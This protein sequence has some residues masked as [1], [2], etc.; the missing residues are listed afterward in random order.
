MEPG[1]PIWGTGSVTDTG[2]MQP[3]PEA[4][5]WSLRAEAWAN[6]DKSGGGSQSGT[7]SRWSDVAA[8]GRPAIPADGVGWRTS[9][10]EWRATTDTGRWRQ[11]TEWR[12]ASGTHGWRQTTEAWQSGDN[13]DFRPPIDPPATQLPAI[14]GTAWPTPD[15]TDQPDSSSSSSRQSF[16]GQS[17]QS[18]D[19]PRWQQRPA[20]A[21]PSWQQSQDPPWQQRPADAPPTWSRG[22][23]APPWQQR[24]ADAPAARPS[25]QQFTTPAGPT[26]GPSAQPADAP[27]RGE[28]PSWDSRPSWQQFAGVDRSDNPPA[29]P[30]SYNGSWSG[31][32][33]DGRHLVREDDREQWRRESAAGQTGYDDRSRPTGRR[34]AAEPGSRTSGG[35]GWTVQSDA[36]NWAGHTDTGSIPRYQDPVTDS[37]S[38]RRDTPS[39]DSWRTNSTADSWHSSDPATTSSGWA[40]TDSPRGWTSSPSDRAGAANG[41]AGTTP[42]D[43]D[44]RRGAES[45]RDSWRSDP[46]ADDRWR[47]AEGGRLRPG[48][49]VSELGPRDTARWRGERPDDPG[50][51]GG[52]P[53]ESSWR[54]EP[55]DDAGRRGE[56]SGD[57]DWR[58]EPSGDAG[59]R[60]EPSDDAGRRR[61]FSGDAGWRSADEA[62]GGSARSNGRRAAESGGY[63]WEAE[64]QA[65]SGGWGEAEDSATRDSWRSGDQSDNTG[66][67]RSGDGSESWRSGDQASGDTQRGSWE[68]SLDARTDWRDGEARP[69]AEPWSSSAAETS[70]I[71]FPLEPRDHTDTG[72]W[73]RDANTDREQS[74]D[75]RRSR[76]DTGSWRRA[77]EPGSA[78]TSPHGA[79]SGPATRDGGSGPTLRD[80]G[81]G[82][83]L[84]DGGSG[85]ALRDGGGSGPTLR[86]GGP[87]EQRRGLDP[88][89]GGWRRN[90][91][92]SANGARRWDADSDPRRRHVDD[93]DDHRSRRTADG[94]DS[95]PWRS[96]DGS[97]S[98]ARRWD[99]D[100]GDSGARRWDADGGDSG[101]RRRDADDGMGGARRR[102]ADPGEPT[103]GWRDG[104]RGRRPGRQRGPE[105]TR[106]PR[107]GLDAQ[108]GAGMPRREGAAA[109]ARRREP[110]TSWQRE[111]ESG[112]W[113]RDPESDV[114][115]RDSDTGQWHRAEVDDD[116]DDEDDRDD[117]RPRRRSRRGGV[118]GGPLAIESAESA[119]RRASEGG[120]RRSAGENPDEAGPGRK[121]VGRRRA[122]EGPLQLGS[123]A[124]AT[125]D[126]EVYRQD[127][128]LPTRPISV[129]PA[130]LQPGPGSRDTTRP[131]RQD[132]NRPTS[133]RQASAPPDRWNDD[134]PTSARQASAPP[135]RWNDDQP[136]SARQASAPPA[137]WDDD[138]PESVGPAAWR[139]A[140][141]AD[142]RSDRAGRAE[143]RRSA[144]D[145]ARAPGR[146][147]AAAARTNGLAESAT[148]PAPGRAEPTDRGQG[149]TE[150]NGGMPGR[151]TPNGRTQGRTEPTDRTRSRGLPEVDPR[152][153]GGAARPVSAR[154][155]GR[156]GTR[157]AGAP[158][159]WRAETQTTA[160]NDEWLS[161]LRAE[162]GGSATQ[163]V[164]RNDEWLNQLRAEQGL[165]TD[166]GPGQGRG[167]AYRDGGSADWRQ[168]LTAD[169]D[170]ADGESRRF[171]T[172]DFVPF[173]P[174]S[175]NGASASVKV[176]AANSASE[177]ITEVI[178]RTGANWQNPPDTEWPPKGAVLSSSAGSYERRPVS[179]IAAATARQSDL[180]EPEEEIEEDTGGP[181]AAVGYTV[182]WYGV[183]VVL[184]VL[185]MLV[186]DGNQR[187]HALGTLADAAPQFGLSLV[188]SMLVAVGLRW[189]SGSWKA[190]SVGLASAVMGGGLA[191]VL[192]SAIT[193]QSLS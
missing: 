101:R 181:L 3:I 111:L 143:A 192:T 163:A 98:G 56:P 7:V 28:R 105:T 113:H 19:A 112:Q 47:G 71:S 148:T 49:N 185:Y 95:G 45:P 168:G 159:A 77:I 43:A 114:W 61:E 147:E 135:D 179:T 165:A 149:R 124:E 156:R 70:R 27:P 188:L 68:Q 23:A 74:G 132:D 38:W 153:G 103:D 189:A 183:P 139:G 92:D 116:E 167:A 171:G 41:R 34:R 73:R 160:R 53:S 137:R 35:T 84:R 146:T 81:S 25:W 117:D 108:R 180:L 187:A 191:T 51:R 1:A 184:F 80:G 9:T 110:D 85:P 150:P 67:W 37:P 104:A 175:K 90:D 93:G 161:K 174:P 57:G 129:R 142:G 15:A 26:S 107:R 127:S 130:P 133:A 87:G 96:A 4:V 66:G 170:L 46:N 24:P 119:Q 86:S 177:G 176:P 16:D 29:A 54:G 155:D 125:P 97:D 78:P 10:S 144:T 164:D 8:T 18:T 11:T 17:W 12:S 91:T 50:R 100:G 121:T 64:G 157:S 40:G 39:G 94:N 118:P 89:E 106:E 145:A 166:L 79:G 2:S 102:D 72:S 123:R 109:Y 193:G 32:F 134:R 186:L 128:D 6:D 30:T 131:D 22:D 76:A 182:V 63:G 31:G 138:R 48:E 5:A 69:S 42:A 158:D 120:A 136:T 122:P 55:S 13:D 75:E 162:Q 88:A 126:P 52:A 140:D 44:A 14:S 190:A 151:T 60:G 178:Q 65:R 172:S 169:S 58:G 21:A 36:D 154:P 59:W 20:D 83:A 99:A 115:L 152:Q 62:R 82:P 141:Q 33:D 173:R